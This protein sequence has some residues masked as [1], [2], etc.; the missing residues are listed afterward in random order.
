MQKSRLKNKYK[1]EE[2]AQW[3][4]YFSGKSEYVSSNPKN[5]CKRRAQW[6]V[7]APPAFYSKMGHRHPCI[8]PNKKDPV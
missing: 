3:I 2:M 5:P 6:G 7:P 8:S 4:K 1:A